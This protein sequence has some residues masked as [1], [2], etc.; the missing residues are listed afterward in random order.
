MTDPFLADSRS[1]WFTPMLTLAPFPFAA[2]PEL[3][4]PDMLP[5]LAALAVV[6]ICELALLTLT[7]LVFTAV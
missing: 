4:A 5:V 7:L 3:L 2:L 1:Y 6:A